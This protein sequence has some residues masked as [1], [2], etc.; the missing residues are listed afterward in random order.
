MKKNMKI[1]TDKPKAKLI[2]K[3][4]RPSYSSLYPVK[5]VHTSVCNIEQFIFRPSDNHHS[6]DVC[7]SLLEA[8]GSALIHKK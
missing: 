5:S 1:H 4:Q 2:A 3:N 8:T 7:W 6:S